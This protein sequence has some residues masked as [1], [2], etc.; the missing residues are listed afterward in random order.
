MSLIT[1]SQLKPGEQAKVLSLKPDK[2]AYRHK[3]LSLGLLPGTVIKVLR[4][5]PF[6]DPIEIDCRGVLLSLRRQ[7]ADILRLERL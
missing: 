7:E 3:L 6:G 4:L 2:S 1:L 5:A